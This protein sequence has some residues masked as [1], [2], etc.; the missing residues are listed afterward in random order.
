MSVEP[1]YHLSEHAR[2]EAERPAQGKSTRLPAYCPSPE[3]D[4]SSPLRYPR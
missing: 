1:L 2:E 4:S 3:F